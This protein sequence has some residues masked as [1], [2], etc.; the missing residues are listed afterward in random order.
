MT[1]IAVLVGS[2]AEGSINKK[3]AKA[4]EEVAPEGVEFV[5]PSVDLPLYNY[6]IDYPQ[7][8]KDMKAEIADADGVLLVTPEY[9]RSMSGAMKNALDWASRPMGE[10]PLSGKPGAI[11][12]ASMGPLGTTQAQQMLR[13]V[14]LFLNMDL[15]GQPELYIDFPNTFEADG[16]LK[17]TS[18]DFLAGYAKALVDHVESAK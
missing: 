18:K 10:N 17:E 12:G 6:E 3:L 15:M 1:K 11:V 13:N 9:N 16:T 14:A 5:Y 7:A 8:A 4:I 2:L